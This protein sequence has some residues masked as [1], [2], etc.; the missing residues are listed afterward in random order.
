MKQR[1]S[2][3]AL[4]IHF[5]EVFTS[6][7]FLQVGKVVHL[8]R[9]PCRSVRFSS[10][11]SRKRLQFNSLYSEKLQSPLTKD[12]DEDK[13]FIKTSVFVLD[14]LLAWRAKLGHVKAYI[15]RGSQSPLHA[16]NLNFP[17]YLEPGKKHEVACAPWAG[18]LLS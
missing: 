11:T 6:S 1:M 2:S 15:T 4:S 17:V 14:L 16:K 12:T 18:G 9:C 3:M 5:Y 10:Q 7:F 8:L 13:D